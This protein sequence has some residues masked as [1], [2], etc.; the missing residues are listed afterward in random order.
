MASLPARPS[1]E[2]LRKQAK[3]LAR[4]RFVGLA[5]AQRSLAHEYGFPSWAEL[6]RHVAGVRGE[7]AAPPSPLFAA[8]HAGDVAAVRRLIAEGANPRLDDGRETPLHAA[9]RRG[10]LAV[11]EALIEGGAF[12]WQTDRKGRLPVDVARR[13]RAAD[14]SAIVALLNRYG[15]PIRRSARRS[16]RSTPATSPRSPRFSMRS[17]VC[18]AGR[19]DTSQELS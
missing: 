8:V 13:G 10:P 18:C 2:H 14:R 19:D 5:T 12:E 11:V 17:R 6:M 16:R 15:S 1:R 7:H 4:E 9:A 3:R